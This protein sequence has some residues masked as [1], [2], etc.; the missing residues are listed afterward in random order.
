MLFC[1]KVTAVP[2]LL[3]CYMGIAGNNPFFKAGA[4]ILK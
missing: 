2:K 3:L 1:I 4:K